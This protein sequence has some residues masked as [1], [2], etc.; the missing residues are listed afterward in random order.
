[1]AAIFPGAAPRA[2]KISPLR[3]WSLL[4]LINPI[5]QLPI[6]SPDASGHSFTLRPELR[7]GLRWL[8]FSPGLHPGLQRFHRYAAF[9]SSPVFRLPTPDFFHSSLNSLS[10]AY[11]LL[12]LS[13]SPLFSFLIL[14][15][16]FT[17]LLNYYSSPTIYYSF[18]HSFPFLRQP[19][20]LVPAVGFIRDG[21]LY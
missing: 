3:G 2:T 18:F 21:H 16:P 17:Q 13:D 8:P 7:G 12:P 20:F 15:H 4:V 9:F 10:T 1:M 6:H 5:T 19:V 11:F 14:I